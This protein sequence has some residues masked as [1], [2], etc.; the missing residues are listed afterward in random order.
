MSDHFVANTAHSGWVNGMRFTSDGLHLVTYGTDDRIKL[1][2]IHTGQNT[3]VNY[4]KIGNEGKKTVEFGITHLCTPDLIFMPNGTDIEMYDLF[5]GNKVDTLRG[6][7]MRVNC[8][9]L[10]PHYQELYSGGS[11]RNIL[12]WT[13]ES[14]SAYDDH[15]KEISKCTE[16]KRTTTTSNNST[17]RSLATADAWS[18]DEDS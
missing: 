12:V 16:E 1:W 8:C 5:N 2:N 11:D 9:I 13:P 10:H 6:H 15:L 14:D 17:Q 3:L 18:S 4:G 7:Y